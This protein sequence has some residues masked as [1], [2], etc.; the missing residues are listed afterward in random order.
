MVKA[1]Y[2][3]PEGE[4][5]NLLTQPVRAGGRVQHLPFAAAVAEF[6]LLLRDAPHDVARWE[7]LARRMAQIDFPP[8]SG[9][10]KDGFKELVAIASGLARLR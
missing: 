6:G 5:S 9:G 7:A 2:K 4:E 3:L 8:A 10:E 1:R